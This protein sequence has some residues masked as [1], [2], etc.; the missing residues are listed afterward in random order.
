MKPASALLERRRSVAEAV[1]DAALQA[2]VE[3]VAAY[4]LCIE[5][6][7]GLELESAMF[8]AC[9]ALIDLRQRAAKAAL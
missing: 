7:Q 5:T 1:R 9:R 2:E 6:G 8:A 4:D 3:L